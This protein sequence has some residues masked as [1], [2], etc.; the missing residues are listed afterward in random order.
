MAYV[1]YEKYIFCNQEMVV[2]VKERKVCWRMAGCEQG[3]E[4]SIVKS[5][6]IVWVDKFV[7]CISEIIGRQ[8]QAKYGS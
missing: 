6:C 3:F 5:D 4:C 8:W 1:V 7:G 2:F